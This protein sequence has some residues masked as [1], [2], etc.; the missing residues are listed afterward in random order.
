MAILLR[1]ATPGTVVI[2]TQGSQ[3]D[4]MSPTARQAVPVFQAAHGRPGRRGRGSR[5]PGRNPRTGPPGSD[6]PR[7]SRSP[8]GT[9]EDQFPVRVRITEE[10][11]LC[12]HCRRCDAAVS[13]DE[14]AALVWLALREYRGSMPKAAAWLARQWGTDLA[15]ADGLLRGLLRVLNR[16]RFWINWDRPSQSGTGRPGHCS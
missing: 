6:R 12:M 2:S 5:R 14:S 15:Y 3:E 10:G 4:P 9:A 1:G 13:L 11:R 8:R 16:A 7:T